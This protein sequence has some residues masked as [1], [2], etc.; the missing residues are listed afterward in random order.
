[1]KKKIVIFLFK[2]ISTHLNTSVESL[3]KVLKTVSNDL[4]KLLPLRAVF[5]S[6]KRKMH[7]GNGI[8]LTSLDD[9]LA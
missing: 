6:G 5:P 3:K 9:V 7:K 2:V 4:L 8:V 1:V